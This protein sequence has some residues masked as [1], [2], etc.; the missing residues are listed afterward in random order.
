M[1][2]KPI[3]FDY[4]KFVQ[5]YPD[6]EVKIHRKN[7]VVDNRFVGMWG[8]NIDEEN[9][10]MAL[11]SIS[12]KREYSKETK[13]TILELWYSILHQ[14]AVDEQPEEIMK[15]IQEKAEKEAEKAR[16]AAEAAK[17]AEEKTKAAQE[18]ITKK[19]N[20]NQEQAS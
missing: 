1:R 15:R 8:E 4:G 5:D 11:T 16:K 12:V 7:V 17:K 3:A 18:K 14:Y 9:K 6:T 20:K 19:Q 2:I 10:I 13:E